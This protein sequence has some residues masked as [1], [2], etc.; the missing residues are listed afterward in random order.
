MLC[1]I[2]HLYNSEMLCTISTFVQFGNTMYK[3]A[4]CTYSHAA[5]GCLGTCRADL[6][7]RH[8]PILQELFTKWHQA[9]MAGSLLKR[10]EEEMGCPA[11]V[12]DF[13]IKTTVRLPKAESNYR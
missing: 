12:A 9:R 8:P 4:L 6:K 10:Q 2:L 7:N 3:L 5:R 11:F 13:T 1:T